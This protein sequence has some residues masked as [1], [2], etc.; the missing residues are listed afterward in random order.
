MKGSIATTRGRPKALLALA[1]AVVF[2]A[3]ACGGGSSNGSGNA[4]IKLGGLWDYTGADAEAGT[5]IAKAAQMVVDDTNAKGGINGHKIEMTNYDDASDPATA[6]AVYRKAVDQDGA[7]LIIGPTFTPVAT[8]V[9]NTG[10]EEKVLVYTIGSTAAVITDPLKKY[11]Y[12]VPPTANDSA[13]A[14]ISLIKSMGKT[15]IG[16]LIEADGY[17]T[18]SQTALTPL[19]A[20]NGLKIVSTATIAANAI[21]ATSQVV[22]LKNSG[23]DVVVIGLLPTPGIP[24]IKAAYQQGLN[25]PTVSF[26]GIYQ[27][28]SEQIVTS[29]APIELYIASPLTCAPIGVNGCA[30]SFLTPF[31]KYYDKPVPGFAVSAYA[32]TLALME[33]LKR[34]KSFKPD[35][36]IAALDS[37]PAYPNDVTLPIKFSPTDH[38]GL[39]DQY[40][41]GFQN[42]KYYFLGNDVKA[43]HAKA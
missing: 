28:A 9:C 21:D 13:K 24:Y 36:V 3:T 10:Q 5:A 7:Q 16:L 18:Q 15:K 8:A 39:H 19:L 30:Q 32:G 23:A 40:L 20:D 37:A 6:V 1:A 35:D 34:A 14:I 42:G 4:A 17:G 31:K 41:E 26:G 12:G 11:C 22:Q 27:P 43:N 25:L 38:R 29:S 33:A 2:L